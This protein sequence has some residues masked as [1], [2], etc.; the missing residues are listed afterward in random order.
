MLFR[1][2]GNLNIDAA[3]LHVL[4]DMCQSIGVIIAG[5]FIWAKPAWQVRQ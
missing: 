3:Y 4:G 1:L 2:S 5:L